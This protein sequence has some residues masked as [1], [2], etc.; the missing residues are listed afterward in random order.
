MTTDFRIKVALLTVAAVVCLC[1]FA[2]LTG[3]FSGESNFE[4]SEPFPE[5]LESKLSSV[6]TAQRSQD[7]PYE[8]LYVIYEEC[9]T[10]IAEHPNTIVP[11]ELLTEFS[12]LM[13][14]GEWNNQN[15]VFMLGYVPEIGCTGEKFNDYLVVSD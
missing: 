1:A 4:S 3:L 10:Y 15:G 9:C 13:L 6:V 5:F 2:V 14:R 8:E 7:T 11:E 12:L